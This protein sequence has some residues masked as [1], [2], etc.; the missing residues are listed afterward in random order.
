MKNKDLIKNIVEGIELERIKNLPVTEKFKLY[1]H[2]KLIYSEAVYANKESVLQLVHS[3]NYT[4]SPTYNLFA[5]LIVN[6]SDFDLIKEIV[7]NYAKSFENS[8]IYYAQITMTGMGLLMIEKQLP[9]ESIFHFLLHLLGEDFLQ[10]NLKTNAC[11]KDLV[12]K[13]LKLDVSIKY[14]PFEGDHRKVKY[15]L[16]ALLKLSHERGLTFVS[17]II[18]EKFKDSKLQF[19]FNMLNNNSEDVLEYLYKDLN[20]SSIRSERLLATGAYTLVKGHSIISSHYLLNSILGKYS[21]YDKRKEEIDIEIQER[22][23]EML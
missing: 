19:Y 23:D 10:N 6:L 18:N 16:L 21:R 14:K 15:D 7:L 1:E 11:S 4:I 5:M 13:N 12:V 8:D 2:I 3:P 20:Q 9:P 17:E 22:I